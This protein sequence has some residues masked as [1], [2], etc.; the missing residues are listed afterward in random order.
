MIHARLVF[1]RES[2]YSR[3]DDGRRRR[4]E[5]ELTGEN[6][7]PVSE[8]SDNSAIKNLT[9]CFSAGSVERQSEIPSNA[10]E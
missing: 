1:P 2:G 9:R 8:E 10:G 7:S 3:V 5:K 6:T 4:S